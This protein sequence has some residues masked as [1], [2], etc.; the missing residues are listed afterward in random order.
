MNYFLKLGRSYLRHQGGA[1][2]VLLALMSGFIAT[3]AHVGLTAFQ[4]QNPQSAA[5]QLV[6]IACQKIAQLD[7]AL[8]ETPGAA[9]TAIETLLNERRVAG[10]DQANGQFTVSH[11]KTHADFVK[12]VDQGERFADLRRYS[13][14]VQYKGAVQGL[15]TGLVA[16]GEA[17]VSATKTCRP[18]CQ[19]QRNVIYNAP[20]AVGHWINWRTVRASAALEDEQGQLVFNRFSPVQFAG[21]R[22]QNPDPVNN[23]LLVTVMTEDERIRYRRVLTL[24]V[25]LYFDAPHIQNRDPEG[26]NV[27]RLVIDEDDQIVIQHMNADGSIPPVCGPAVCEDSSCD[28][29]MSEP[30]P[31]DPP[32]TPINRCAAAF[33]GLNLP[34]VPRRTQFA[35]PKYDPSKH[36]IT[37]E[38]PRNGRPGRLIF[39]GHRGNG[40]QFTMQVRLAPFYLPNTTVV[41]VVTK[42]GSIEKMSM[43]KFTALSHMLNQRHVVI[44]PNRAYPTHKFLYHLHGANLTYWWD[45]Q[46]VCERFFSPLVFDT[47]GLGT[48]HTTRH[49]AASDLRKTSPLFDF[50]GD[51]QNV[52]V[53]WPIGPGQAW[54]IDNRDGRAAFAMNGRRFF[55]SFD[56]F[57]DGYEH[58]A[59]LDTSGTGLL[60]GDDLKGLAL[61]FDNGNARV[62]EGELKSLDELG[63]TAIETR[64]TSFILPDGRA[65]LRATAMMQ[66]RVIM[67]EDLFVHTQAPDAAHLAQGQP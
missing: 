44:V 42:T 13:F 7:P 22:L 47:L 46:D 26:P 41:N 51:G 1:Y 62:E 38:Y 28:G 32:V 65:A 33:N 6:D 58:L 16:S 66:G 19:G 67:T 11:A 21:N 53:E 35:L 61:W 29:S 18:V 63:I 52:H 55:G 49:D 43:E 20:T 48:I 2:A 64:A 17:P 57:A 3:A 24:P 36:D 31:V 25:N 27:Q 23:R 54:L 4:I 56:D 5:E 60:Q 30:P 45:G 34:H 10:L 37:F 14:T 59:S 39:R 15:K 8:Y 40:S 9:A 50:D 12:P